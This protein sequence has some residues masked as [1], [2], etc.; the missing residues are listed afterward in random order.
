MK[1]SPY[2]LSQVAKSRKILKPVFL[3]RSEDPYC[4]GG[5]NTVCKT[6]KLKKK[7]KKTAI[8]TTTVNVKERESGCKIDIT[9]ASGELVTIT[10]HDNKSAIIVNAP[11]NR[12]A[13]IPQVSNEVIVELR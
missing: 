10:V 3:N 6:N 13:I 11:D 8:M 12:L 7:D 5:K 9:L 1:Y 4:C 2:D